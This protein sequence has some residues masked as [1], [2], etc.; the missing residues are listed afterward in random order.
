MSVQSSCEEPVEP[1]ALIGFAFKFP[2]DATSSDDFWKLL[3]AK[4][5]VATEIPADRMNL[6]GFYHPEQSRVDGLHVRMAHFLK[7]DPGAFD[8]P[9]FSI[10]PAEAAAMD[11]QHRC[12][13][14]AS[15]HALENAGIP[16]EE[17]SGTDTAVF[18]GSFA[19]DFRFLTLK[20]H[21]NMSPYAGSS[22]SFSILANRLSW[23]FNF[24]GPSVHIDTACS[25]S[26]VALHLACQNLRSR[27]ASMALVGG[28]NVLLSDQHYL[29]M[30]NLSM[31]SPSGRCHS[32]D[33]RA[34]G[35]ARGEGFGVV[36]LKRL[37]DALAHG[38]VIRAVIRATGTNQDGRTP[39]LT[40]PSQH[41]QEKL[42]RDTYN[43]AKLSLHETA[44]VEAH[45]TG[46]AVG[47]PIE[48]RAIGS[49]FG[50]VQRAAGHPLYIGSIKSNIGHL[51]GGSGIASLIKAVLALEK[52]VI[53]PNANFEKR[54]PAIDP[55]ALNIIFPTEL[56]PWPTAGL[57]RV[58]VNSFGFGGSNAHVVLDDAANYLRLRGLVHGHHVSR[59]LSIPQPSSRSR[60][61]LDGTAHGRHDDHP[62]LLIWSASDNRASSRLLKAFSDYFFNKLSSQCFD[63]HSY[64]DDLALTL[65]ARRSLL[66][67]RSFAIASSASQLASSL[68]QLVSPPR[69][70]QVSPRLGFIFTGQ[71]AQ[72]SKMGCQ[73]LD[74]YGVFRRSMQRS[75]DYL[76]S[77]GCDWNL[78][79]EVCKPEQDTRV[80]DPDYSQPICTALQL[81]LVDLLRSFGVTPQK[82]VG[83]SSGEIAAAYSI[84]S[85][86]QASALK[87][88][89]FR[90]KVVAGLSSSESGCRPKG[91]MLAVGLSEFEA[92]SLVTSFLSDKIR[93]DPVAA[94]SVVTACINSPSSV[95][96]AGDED[97]ID[98]INTFLDDR[99]IFARKL[100]VSVAYHS[101]RH[102]E[103]ASRQYRDLLLDNGTESLRRPGPSRLRQYGIAPSQESSPVMISSV[104]GQL[105]SSPDQFQDPEYW[106]QNMTS[107]VRFSE[108]ISNAMLGEEGPVDMVEIG[109]HSAL[110]GPFSE[111]IASLKLRGP[112]KTPHYDS[113]LDRS[114]GGGDSAMQSLLGAMGRLHCLGHHVDVLAVNALKETDHGTK[115]PCSPL[116]SLPSY[117]FDHTRSYWRESRR[118]REFR[119]RDKSTR[120]SDLLGS[121]VLDF[122]ANPPPQMARRW[123]KI[124]RVAETPWVADHVVNGAVIYPAAGMLAMVLEAASQDV[125][126][127]SFDQSKRKVSAFRIAE[128]YFVRPLFVPCAEQVSADDGVESH[129]ELGP[130]SIC[131]TN[132]TNSNSKKC[133]N[134]K[135]GCSSVQSRFTLCT[136]EDKT[137]TWTENCHGTIV[138]EYDDWGEEDDGTTE[139][140]AASC[141]RHVDEANVYQSFARM[142][143]GFSNSFR[144]LKRVAVASSPSS[145][146]AHAQV[147]VF[148]K[149]PGDDHIIY[150]TTL[151][152]VFQT[153]LVAL[154]QPSNGGN[155]QFP[156]MVPTKVED[157]W[158]ASQGIGYP[159]HSSLHVIASS[160]QTEEPW[161]ESSTGTTASSSASASGYDQHG[162]LLL[163]VGR[164]ETTCIDLIP[165][166]T[167]NSTSSP[168]SPQRNQVGREHAEDHGPC[169]YRVS[170]KPD[171]DLLNHDVIPRAF[172][173]DAGDENNRAS[174]TTDN[175]VLDDAEDHFNDI[176]LLFY[177]ICTRVLEVL[178]PSKIPATR[179]YL[180]NYIEWMRAHVRQHQEFADH[181]R[182]IDITRLSERVART[183][184]VGHG[185]VHIIGEN[186]LEVL[187]GDRDPLELIFRQESASTHSVV[188]DNVSNFAERY[189]HEANHGT[190]PAL[191]YIAEL[192]TFKRP[193]L[194]VLE[195]GAGT[196][197]TTEV[198]LKQ[199]RS[200]ATDV[201]ASAHQ[202]V[203]GEG[204]ISHYEFTDVSASFFA[205][206]REKLAKYHSGSTTGMSMNFSVLDITIDPAATAHQ[207][208][209]Y[210][211]VVAANVLHATPNLDV[212]LSHVRKLLKPETGKLVLVEITRNQWVPQVIFGLLEG[213]WVADDEYRHLGGGYRKDGPCISAS[214]WN[215]ALK[216]N[217]FTG[218]TDTVLH[219]SEDPEKGICSVIVASAS[220]SGSSAEG[221]LPGATTAWPPQDTI[222]VTDGGPDTGAV[223][224]AVRERILNELTSP[225][226]TGPN[227]S[228]EGCG[229][230]SGQVDI[231]CGFP[232][233]KGYSFAE[234]K[235]CISLLELTRPLLASMDENEFTTVRN[236][237]T[238]NTLP[239][240]WKDSER[241]G[242][243]WVRGKGLDSKEAPELH[244]SDGLFRVLRSEN[245]NKRFVTLALSSSPCPSLSTSD[246]GAWAGKVAAT[247]LRVAKR[248]LL[249]PLEEMESGYK[250]IDYNDGDEF[251]NSTS[252]T[253][254][255]ISR[256]LTATNINYHV[257][258]SLSRP[259]GDN[260]NFLDPRAT[261]V[262]A[263]GFGGVARNIARWMVEQGG[264]R[265]LV[266]LS[267]SGPGKNSHQ[268]QTFL[269]D[270]RR[271]Y[272]ELRVEHPVCDISSPTDLRRSVDELSAP[273]PPVRG[274]IQGAL[275][276]QD[277]PF[278]TMTHTQWST[279]L[280][281]RV[282]GTRNL[283]TLF[284]P[285]SQPQQET[286]PNKKKFKSFMILLSSVNGVL[287]NP[288]QANYAAANAY[289]DAF[290][291]Y[292]CRFRSDIQVVSI[293]LGWVDF[294][295]TVAESA[296]LQRR[297]AELACLAP[298]SHR[299]MMALMEHVAC[300]ESSKIPAQIIT[301]VKNPEILAPSLPSNR[302][303]SYLPNLLDRPFWRMVTSRQKSPSTAVKKSAKVTTPDDAASTLS[304]PKLLSAAPTQAEACWLIL[305]ALAKRLAT[306][307]GFVTDIQ[308]D[309]DKH[310]DDW[311]VYVSRIADRPLHLSGVDSLMAVR[312]RGWFRAMV[313]ADVSVFQ[314]MGAQKTAKELCWEI[315]GRSDLVL[316]SSAVGG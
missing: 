300:V 243:L 291:H 8:A 232:G 133:G 51:E 170:W 112:W 290:A 208:G 46:T 72:Y 221:F 213:W 303:D 192:L 127:R 199:F 309:D 258:A 191:R 228:K 313:G 269:S 70:T 130:W 87:I 136:L 159:T 109:P 67:S 150:P 306:D 80:H 148:H 99:G 234:A 226:T 4:R 125:H 77:L 277:A 173:S 131:T 96:L 28:S 31:L 198:I 12:L 16:L 299:E 161:Y 273:L 76:R 100:R 138:L 204:G 30:A 128:A 220:S 98:A 169:Y 168:S 311:E 282:G 129:F 271:D 257:R 195:I 105:V 176:S 270:L 104:T 166:K 121:P 194:K 279:A 123:R 298:I 242:V 115:P 163:R 197:S 172:R 93:H 297:M 142:G 107:P 33:H 310:D 34:D 58:S 239:L 235:F 83:H 233:A 153:M 304:L 216:K 236:I 145:R 268:A 111:T 245:P 88:A 262:I 56:I 73:L 13:L 114:A 89:Y 200:T 37:S 248:S 60:S 140:S 139:Y 253:T 237:L 134:E 14:E 91:A 18:T 255:G 156:T 203:G 74:I 261:Y 155:Q 48:A 86:T 181:R 272:P 295:G 141:M 84:G 25:S 316:F 244:L 5:C 205:P 254:I 201:S 256:A 240:G 62:R 230:S 65:A 307:M 66:P 259:R 22:T 158:I 102:M 19:D 152:G 231:V 41:A 218:G 137:G 55:E 119:L 296:S 288:S 21:E 302:S 177:H 69:R 278:D 79:D 71:G 252:T 289:L 189:Y 179:P 57:R 314:I 95:T 183:S 64:L 11:P 40:M 265:C 249:Q 238:N 293:D 241:C 132:I 260:I 266:L 124:T 164:L 116:V 44:F 276:L 2:Q 81:G 6:D 211:L 193:G 103:P 15:Y 42:I 162:K 274:I 101:P 188:D 283:M 35:Y 43:K 50:E 287:G 149:P 39:S 110:R 301:G 224:E 202:T 186:L 215:E 285:P 165:S 52:G 312:L 227:A 45:G 126:V 225:L 106:V 92:G 78:I 305:D 294:A 263:G 207:K 3:E 187:H 209:Y 214:V 20:D 122:D 85:L 146:T 212:T 24:K 144:S 26:L 135:Y 222:I 223:A 264:A 171:I 229:S 47:D 147:D 178:D 32:F 157:L 174:T 49:V 97:T 196:G 210:D 120:R 308:E 167:P 217:G 17:V 246:H 7:E 63:S 118:S 275:V 90:G 61:L 53:P 94:E 59:D 250:E 36:V 113:I 82:V 315:A 10:S 23:W 280:S 38:D 185:L 175:T 108:A 151:D 292:N 27:D 9:F 180:H 184:V 247:I 154:T 182:E 117:P 29:L 54:N 143:L 190:E 75:Q 284:P 219:D 251:R 68:P 206:A 286:E 160:S 1:I 281:A 267:R